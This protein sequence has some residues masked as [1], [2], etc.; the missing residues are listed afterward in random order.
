MSTL[1]TEAKLNFKLGKKI[2]K[3]GEGEVYEANDHQLNAILAV[4]KVSHSKFKDESLFFE[5]SKKLYL[6]R[7]RNV[8]EINYGCKDDDHI[9]LAMPFYQNGSLKG[10]CDNRFLS[11]REIIRYGL[12]FL[13][14]L[15]HIHSKGL[16]HFDVKL[17]NILISNSNQ[18]LISDFGLAQ[19]TG[20][21]GFSKVFGTTQVYAPPELFDQAEHNLKFDIYQAGITLLRMCVSDKIFIDQI[22]QAFVKK[23][24]KADA[25]FIERLKNGQF[26]SRTFYFPH[27]P[28]PLRKVIASALNP[29]PNKRYDTI[30]EMQNDLAKIKDAN[31]WLF[32]TDFNGN[33]TWTDNKREVKAAFD[34]TNWSIKSLKSGRQKKD[35]CKVN[36]ND[37]EKNSLLYIALMSNW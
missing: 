8:V 14:G 24:A 17:E 2:G 36:L 32:N 7:H 18:A 31:D 9:Y 28:K 23:G 1:L 25:H 12:Q 10:I 29:N 34:G 13:S 11:S 16:I 20:G 35:F 3:G 5:E 21:Y 15:H 6:T 30:L 26:P 4:K 27:I 22:A 19:Y 37:S 33:E